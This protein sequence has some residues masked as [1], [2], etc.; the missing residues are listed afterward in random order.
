MSTRTYDFDGLPQHRDS[1]SPDLLPRGR[2]QAKKL[3]ENLA[4]DATIWG[5][6]AVLQYA[7]LSDF[8]W[9][10]PVEEGER[11]NVFDHRRG[12]AGPEF[13][14]FRVPNV[15]TLYSN[16]WISLLSG[17]V[18][19]RIPDVGEK[20][21][22][23]N[24]FDTFGNASNVG[25]RTFGG[26]PGLVL[27]CTAQ[28]AE[29]LPADRY[30]EVMIMATP[31]V[32]ALLRVQVVGTNGVEDADRLRKSFTLHSSAASGDADK[33]RQVDSE[34]V[35]AQ[36]A[37][38]A[39]ALDAVIEISGVPAREEGLAAR[40]RALGIGAGSA[41]LDP[42]LRDAAQTG[43][44]NAMDV[45]RESRSQLGTPLGT[46]WTKV[47]D[48]GCHGMN[49][50]AR[51]VMNNVGLGANVVEENASFNAYFD[52]TGAQLDGRN[53]AY[54]L[55]LSEAPPVRY[56]WS[57]TLY[58]AASGRVYGNAWGRYS[59]GSESE[60]HPGPDGEVRI[61]IDPMFESRR[62]AESPHVL[63]APAEPFFVVIRNYGPSSRLAEGGWR[64][65][66][67]TLVHNVAGVET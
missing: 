53:G 49:F 67:I 39:R 60:I 35:E 28:Q 10:R 7:Q 12:L 46:G 5:L 26:G 20:Y 16:G 34:L 29:A 31:I 55:V 30:A 51:A 44:D 1:S 56:F 63:P 48:K 23:V 21:Y 32:W 41:P 15:D 27:L 2:S 42:D 65:G 11:I 54:E 57:L 50:V 24:L 22:T 17:P 45:V 4:F 3:I 18:E 33:V 62:L 8:V 40:Y 59:V 52:A 19:L 66:A 25:S 9:R 43:F 37:E 14:E 61:A 6:P 38:F 58:I 13:S 36:W 47:E 64:P